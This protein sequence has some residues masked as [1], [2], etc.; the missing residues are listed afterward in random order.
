LEYPEELNPFGS[1]AEEDEADEEEEESGQ[2]EGKARQKQ[3]ETN[4]PFESDSD[5]EARV[6]THGQP[7]VQLGNNGQGRVLTL[8]RPS[9]AAANF[10]WLFGS[11]FSA[12]AQKWQFFQL[13]FSFPCPNGP[14]GTK[15]TAKPS[16]CQ[17]LPQSALGGLRRGREAGSAPATSSTSSIPK[18][19]LFPQFMQ[20]FHSF[21][22][23]H[24]V[25]CPF[26]SGWKSSSHPSKPVW[27]STSSNS[28]TSWTPS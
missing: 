26:D 28:C 23:P 8:E 17:P 19:R 12:N 11:F 27:I 25:Q 16:C 14:A 24:S 5:E 22:C 1:D 13:G 2:K 4:N 3:Q 18:N 15:F 21:T 7:M 20:I 9:E 6:K 10:R